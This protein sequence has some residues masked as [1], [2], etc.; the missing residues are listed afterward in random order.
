MEKIE[1]YAVGAPEICRG[2]PWSLQRSVNKHGH[3]RKLPEVEK[4]PSKRIR[5]HNLYSSHRTGKRSGSIQA[6]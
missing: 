1:L 2:S 6:E 5:G 4:E 3:V